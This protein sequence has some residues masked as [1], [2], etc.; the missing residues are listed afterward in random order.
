MT[1]KYSI[2]RR[3]ILCWFL[4]SSFTIGSKY[5]PDLSPSNANADETNI[6]QETT[7]PQKEHHIV[8]WLESDSFNSWL[9]K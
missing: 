2:K 6:V 5:L 3:L 8:S 1:R 7:A 9:E 4:A